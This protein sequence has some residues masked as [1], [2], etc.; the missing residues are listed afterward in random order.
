MRTQLWIPGGRP[1]LEVLLAGPW[2]SWSSGN[3]PGLLI[4][5]LLSQGAHKTGYVLVAGTLGSSASSLPPALSPSGC[6]LCGQWQLVSPLG[7][8][9]SVLK[10]SGAEL[11][12]LF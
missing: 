1:C 11:Q 6:A 9:L 3:R 10:C 8:V 12:G 2:Q 5:T 7:A 4:N